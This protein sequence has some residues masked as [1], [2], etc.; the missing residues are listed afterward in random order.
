MPSHAHVTT[1]STHSSVQS[2]FR[3]ANTHHCRGKGND[4]DDDGDGQAKEIPQ[5]RFTHC[6][7]TT[8]RERICVR[9]YACVFVLYIL[10]TIACI[11]QY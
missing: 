2:I 3:S 11:D 7:Y 9:V 10:H 4:D 1:P 5:Q 8:T 6:Y